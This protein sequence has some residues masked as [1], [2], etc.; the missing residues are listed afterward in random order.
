MRKF[1]V[2]CAL[3]GIVGPFNLNLGSVKPVKLFSLGTIDS[4]PN[5]LTIS[6]IDLTA[7]TATIKNETTGWSFIYD[8]LTPPVLETGENYTLTIERDD[9]TGHNSFIK[10]IIPDGESEI[11][12]VNP[13]IMSQITSANI[14]E[15]TTN[16][17]GF[18]SIDNNFGYRAFDYNLSPSVN[19][20]NSIIVLYSRRPMLL[21]AVDYVSSG[22]ES[23]YFYLD[24][25]GSNDKENWTKIEAEMGTRKKTFKLSDLPIEFVR[26]AKLTNDKHYNYYK[27]SF[28][29]S[30]YSTTRALHELWLTE[31]YFSE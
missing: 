22:Y 18:A 16:P 31:A 23:N 4:I 3:D 24:F 11:K 13:V 17:E 21:K 5:R 9:G 8:E 14:T 20:N 7:N 2:F 1:M 25:Y 12:I 28:R 26:Y 30:N 15:V 10:S 19:L 27:I 6:G 29:E